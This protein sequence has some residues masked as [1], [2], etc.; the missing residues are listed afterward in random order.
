MMLDMVRLEA[1]AKLNRQRKVELGQFLTLLSFAKPLE[2]HD[3]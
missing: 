2:L 3:S 1:S